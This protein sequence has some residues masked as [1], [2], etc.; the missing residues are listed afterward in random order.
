MITFSKQNLTFGA[1]FD[2]KK[3]QELMKQAQEATKNSE[4]P[5]AQTGAVV[6][7]PDGEVIGT[8]WNTIPDEFEVCGKNAGGI[9]P[10]TNFGIP[11][12]KDYDKSCLAIHA[13]ARAIADAGLRNIQKVAGDKGAT[14]FL[15]GHTFLCNGCSSMVA[16]AKGIKD[17]YVQFKDGDPIKHLSR[18]ELMENLEKSHKANLASLEATYKKSPA[19][20]KA[21]CGA[22][23]CS[24]CGCCSK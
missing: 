17:I 1:E 24:H 9:C 23:S 5:R 2:A 18:K 22:D 20:G 3:Q 15:A 16:L 11:S 14:L 19:T 13:E 8:G 6:V 12:G 21:P 10:R 7:S 4:C